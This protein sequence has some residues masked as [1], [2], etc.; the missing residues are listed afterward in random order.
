MKASP[1]VIDRKSDDDESEADQALARIA[2]D[3]I[4]DDREADEREDDGHGR[5][6]AGAERRV[7]AARTPQRDH[8]E[9]E[10]PEENPFG[11]DDA[12]HDLAVGAGQHEDRR[13]D[14]LHDDRE[15]RRA[16]PRMDR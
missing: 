4:D 7:V 8:A 11:V 15:I 16:M 9:R 2:R 12:R 13:P 14:G 6:S 10:R 1:K 5:K 3:L